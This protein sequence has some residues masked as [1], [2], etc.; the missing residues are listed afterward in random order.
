MSAPPAFLADALSFGYA[1]AALPAVADVSARVARSEL[2]AVIGPN[3][4][5]KSTFA[6]LLLGVLRPASGRVLYEGRPA[7][8]WPRREL[9]RRVGVVP[10]AEELV[11]PLTVRALVAMGRYPHLGAWRAEGAA[12]RDAVARA[13]AACDVAHLT[14]RLVTHLSGG[15]RQRARIARALAQE[16][17]TLVLDEPTAALDIAHEMAI[18]ELL[19][20][21]REERGVTV[22]LVTHNINLAARYADRLLLLEQGRAL[23]EG[24][25]A[26]V[27][28]RALIERSYH[29][30]VN[31]FSHAGPGDDAGAPQV[32]PL[33]RL[34]QTEAPA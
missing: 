25:P 8:E 6:R 27:V 30:P 3:G 20:R 16:P 12:D 10:Q 28:T 17:D 31:V 14:D 24:P 22:L 29:W 19:V 2:F 34:P 32:T 15:E 7:A 26:A 21:L 11:F 4:S 1:G 9:A 13:L 18:F 5:G 23:A 33:A